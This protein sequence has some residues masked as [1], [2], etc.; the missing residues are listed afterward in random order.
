MRRLQFVLLF[1]VTIV[2]GGPS[3]AVTE[4]VA[5]PKVADVLAQL[6]RHSDKPMC[7]ND[8]VDAKDHTLGRYLAEQLANMETEGDDQIKLT[9][10]AEKDG[11]W[12]CN[13]YFLHS[14]KNTEILVSNGV[15]VTLDRR[16]VL[17]IKSLVCI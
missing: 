12:S 4:P 13:L 3:V 6:F 2:A 8:I 14:V 7:E 11:G 5:Q 17:E 9:C 16:G 10:D 1:L 15:R